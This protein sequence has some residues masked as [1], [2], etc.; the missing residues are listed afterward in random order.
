MKKLSL[1]I[2]LVL[3]L[4]IPVFAASNTLDYSSS[5]ESATFFMPADELNKNYNDSAIKY[6]KFSVAGLTVRADKNCFYDFDLKSVTYKISKNSFN[7]VFTYNDNSEK[8]LDT[9]RLDIK[10]TVTGEGITERSVADFSGEIVTAD[11]VKAGELVF[12]TKKLG[13]FKVTEYKFTDVSDPE[14]WYYKYVNGC[15]ALGI[16]SGMGDGTF[17]PQKTVTRAELAVMIV[18]ATEHLISYRIAD[19]VS[20]TDVKKGKWYYDY[21]MKCASVGI[22]FGKGDGK[23]APNDNATREEIAALTA[24]VIKI[25]GSFNGAPIPEITDVSTLATLYPDGNA[26]SKYAKADVILCNKLSVMVGDKQ[27]FRPKANT[28]RAECAKIFFDIKNS[29]K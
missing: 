12:F 13:A 17:M 1:I 20:F 28:T 5:G 10:Y 27:G 2:V 16:L 19:G 8:T 6:Y 18:K 24:R 26:V 4:S 21:V 22:I 29:L 23:F 3:C 9:A 15:A 25:A 14:A 11:S 7:A